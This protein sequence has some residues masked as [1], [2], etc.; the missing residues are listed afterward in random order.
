VTGGRSLPFSQCR[1]SCDRRMESSSVLA[2]SFLCSEKWSILPFSQFTHKSP[3]QNM[4]AEECGGESE[5]RLPFS[6]SSSHNQQHKNTIA[7]EYEG[8]SETFFKNPNNRLI[9]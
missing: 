5:S 1:L 2:V 4:I 3:T 8:E 6:R 7:E 9:D